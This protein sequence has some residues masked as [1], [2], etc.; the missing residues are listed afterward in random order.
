VPQAATTVQAPEPSGR[1]AFATAPSTASS[2]GQVDT[3][4]APATPSG[5]RSRASLFRVGAAKADI[6]PSDA[7][8]ASG[9]VYLGGYGYG[10]DPSHLAKGVLRHVYARA[11]AIGD[12]KHQVVIVSVDTQGHFIAYEQGPYGFA[13]IASDVQAKL[14]I[15]A[16]NVIIQTTHTHNGTDD[17]GAWGG[18]PD[19]FL[20]F[21]KTQIEL[22]ITEAVR[23]EKPAYLRWGTIGMHGFSGTFGLNPDNPKDPTGDWKDYPMDEQLRA[24]QAVSPS[25]AVIANMVNYSSHPTIYGPMGKVSPDWPGATATYLEHSE[26]NMPANSTYGFPGS[27]AVVTVGAIGHTW[28]A[29]I[30]PGD[31]ASVNPP[32]TDDNYNADLYGNAV[33]QM[34]IRALGKPTYVTDGVIG[35]AQQTFAVANTNPLLLAN[36]TLPSAGPS[37]HI[38]RANTPPWGAV[39]A[40]WTRATALRVGNL[41]LFSGPGEPYPSIISTLNQSVKDSSVNFIFGLG[42]DQLGYVEELSD[43]NSAFQCSTTDEWFFTIS[44]AFGYDLLKSQLANAA[45]LGFGTNAT[46]L[47]GLDPGPVPPSTNCTQ[48]NLSQI[49]S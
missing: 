33:A 7:L 26:L 48:Q 12:G 23:A 17:L 2:S 46:P 28:P 43:Y 21:E 30:P 9:Q 41:A 44:P 36:N 15:P 47:T 1:F 38:Y 40:Y 34:A 49:H 39:D 22:A 42:Q 27:V 14:H 35:G 31:S 29:G 25:G 13:D 10:P 18:V 6:T 45:S 5:T 16:S 32:S 4:L 8:I 20:A 19:A 37:P 11:I 3:Q 24:L